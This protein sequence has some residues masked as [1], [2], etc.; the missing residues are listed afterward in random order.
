[1]T[2]VAT[3]EDHEIHYFGNDLNDVVRGMS[4]MG[5]VFSARQGY[6]ADAPPKEGEYKVIE[7]ADERKVIVY[8]NSGTSF[9][10]DRGAVYTAKQ[11]KKKG[12]EGEWYVAFA[13]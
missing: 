7:V 1:M 2:S 11:S 10:T 9:V 12:R 6:I 5:G 13:Y 4:R 3:T 8:T